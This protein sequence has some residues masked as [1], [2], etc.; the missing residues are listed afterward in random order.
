C[1]TWARYLVGTE[2]DID[3]AYAWGWEELARLEA[4]KDIECARILPGGTF[5]EVRQ[6][7]ITDPAR[8]ID[9]VHAY[10]E[11]LQYVTDEAIAGLDGT[12]FSIPVE[13][14]RCEVRIPPG[15][16]AAAAYYT[17]PSE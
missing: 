10:R 11:W 14:R 3:E 2:L 6:L 1:R 9:G 5:E 16:S 13:I 12:A 7:L 8:S 15:G 4:Q 17:P